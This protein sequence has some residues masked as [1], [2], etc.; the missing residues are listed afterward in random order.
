MHG[1]ALN[2]ENTLEGFSY[3]IPCGLRGVPMTTLARE[4]AMKISIDKVF[5]DLT[6]VF[7]GFLN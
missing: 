2:V 4:S 7:A 5:D 6:N 3:I 1:M